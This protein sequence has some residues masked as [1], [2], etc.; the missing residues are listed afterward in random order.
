MQRAARELYNNKRND[1]RSYFF[2]VDRLVLIHQLFPILDIQIDTG[3][4]QN[5]P[6]N[7]LLF[8]DQLFPRLFFLGARGRF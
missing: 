1:K 4:S 2:G 7:L 6:L 5:K 3:I 8:I